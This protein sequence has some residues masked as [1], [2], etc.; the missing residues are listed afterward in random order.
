MR[1]LTKNP[2]SNKV[3]KNEL[4]G[5]RR[6]KKDIGM[7]KTQGKLDNTILEKMHIAIFILSALYIYC[8]TKMQVFTKSN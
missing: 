5:P 8:D 6:I 4:P 7:L 2:M 3:D 1:D